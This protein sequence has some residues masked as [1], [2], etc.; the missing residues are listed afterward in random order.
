M[1]A[2]VTSQVEVGENDG[3]CLPLTKCVCGAKFPSWDE[4]LSVYPDRPWTCPK[5]QTKLI[6][7]VDVKIYRVL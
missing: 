1:K 7:S 6:F 3:E 4:V 5:C 2:D